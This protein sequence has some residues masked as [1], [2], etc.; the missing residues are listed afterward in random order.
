MPSIG[1]LAN[2]VKETST[3]TGTGALTL[4]GAVTGY[5]TFSSAIGTN[6]KCYYTI[7]HQTAAEY[8]IGIGT[9]GSGTL[10]RS[11]VLESSNSNAAVNFSSGTKNVFVSATAECLVGSRLIQSNFNDFG[12]ANNLGSGGAYAVGT[13]GGSGQS[14]SILSSS[15]YPDAVGVMRLISGTTASTGL[16]LLSPGSANTIWKPGICAMDWATRINVSAASS[17]TNRY[18]IR[19]GMVVNTYNADP[20]SGI[21]FRA[22]DNVNSGNYQCVTRA[23]SSENVINT[24][25]APVVSGNGWDT[26]NWLINDAGTSVEF[27]INNVSQGSITSTIPSVLLISGIYM[28]KISGSSSQNLDID[29]F[30]PMTIRKLY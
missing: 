10:T 24:S 28:N 5:R 12:F 6:N 8:E 2:R 17:G 14:G 4:A 1:F 7:E 23:A 25:I 13:Q 20:T 16:G 18:V 15:T 3:T 27:F 21:F 29:W 30:D 22:T 19:M 9:V 11:L 26:L